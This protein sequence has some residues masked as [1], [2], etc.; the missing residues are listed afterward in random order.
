MIRISEQGPRTANAFVCRLGVA[1]TDL[2]VERRMAWCPVQWADG[3]LWTHQTGYHSL[4]SVARLG[5][6]LAHDDGPSIGISSAPLVLSQSMRYPQNFLRQA[7]SLRAFTTFNLGLPRN[8]RTC[9]TMFSYR[10][11]ILDLIF[12]DFDLSFILWRDMHRV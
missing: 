10:A 2:E 8:H 6:F 4:F 7:H 1:Y 12:L 9:P 11:N 5:C 3:C